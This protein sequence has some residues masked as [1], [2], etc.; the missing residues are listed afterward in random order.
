MHLLAVNVREGADLTSHRLG[1]YLHIQIVFARGAVMD[2]KLIIGISVVFCFV[3]FARVFQLYIWPR[4]EGLPR[5][6]ALNLLVAPHMFRFVGL[7]FLYPGVVSPDMAP[8][9]ANPA[10]YGDLA[11]AVVAVIASFSLTAR[12]PW[13]LAVVWLLN[14]EGTVDLLLAYYQGVV[15][16]VLP[17]GALGAAF[18]IPTLIVPPLLVTHFAMYR[19]M[20]RGPRRIAEAGITGATPS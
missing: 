8:A 2:S 20:I 4:L 6:D 12:A 18:F 15:G 11:A 10:A 7:G 19:L 17:P 5:D 3:A 13:A 14:L 1:I 9:F 16:V